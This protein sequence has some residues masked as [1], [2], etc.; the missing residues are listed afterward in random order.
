MRNEIERFISPVSNVERMGAW[1]SAAHLNKCS[2]FIVN[3]FAFYDGINVS[4][5]FQIVKGM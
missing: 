2:V 4:M 3:L 5:G 1:I